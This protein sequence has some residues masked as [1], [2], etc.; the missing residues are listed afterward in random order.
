MSTLKDTKGRL[1]EP[2]E[3][4]E[5][6]ATG[7]AGVTDGDKGDVVV[8]G[9]GA[10]WEL[11]TSG[12][13]PGSYGGSADSCAITVDEKGRITGIIA[14]PIS[15]NISTGTSGTLPVSRG[16]TAATD[17]PTALTNLGAAAASHT[18]P[19]SDIANL[20]TD[21]AAK[22]PLASPALTGTPSGPTAAPGTNTTQLA[23]TAF[24][25]AAVDAVPAVTPSAS[26][27]AETSFGQSAAAGSL[28]TYSRGDHTHGTPAAPTPASIGAAPAS[29]TQAV[30]TLTFAATDRLAGRAS[31]GAG[32]GEEIVCTAAGRALLDDA[33]AAAQRTT[34][35]AA[36]A[37][38]TQ[39]VSTVTFAATDRLAGRSS[40]GAGAGEEIT[41]TAA[42]RALLDD[43]DAAAQRTTLGLGSAALLSEASLRS[44]PQNS[45]TAA[46]VLVVGDVGKH[47][48]IT[49]GGVTVN[50]SVFSAGDPL[51]I[52]NNS[53]SN[54]TIT[55]GTNVTLRL[56]G[57]AT[58][59]NRTLAQYGVCTLLCVVGGAN[60]VFAISGAGL[61]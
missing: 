45:Q 41:C 44:I 32:A 55:Q 38:H 1:T 30:T 49:T 37:S 11:K 2:V 20:V 23:T 43:A 21:L 22:A 16:G 42:G 34:L 13:T 9:G 18:H 31:A 40:A 46:Y 14:D 8:S 10:N 56:A 25:K 27:V 35:G 57:T 28:T 5:P 60:P 4:G 58:T 12:V 17:A 51:T 47:I 50:A 26:V 3:Y 61:S 36:A 6:A 48:S 52:F 54:Q 33:D 29:H 19:E 53:G 15:V 7:G 24:V 39:A 59:G